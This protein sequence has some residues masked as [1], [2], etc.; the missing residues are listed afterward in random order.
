MLRRSVVVTLALAFIA[1]GAPNTGSSPALS[2][3]G[4]TAANEAP[5]AHRAPQPRPR[6]FRI[7]RFEAC[8]ANREQGE[9]GST[10]LRYVNWRAQE[11]VY[12]GGYSMEPSKW[13]HGGG[14]LYAQHPWLASPSDQTRVF[15]RLGAL[16]EWTP[17]NWPSITP[18][19]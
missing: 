10:D 5:L 2:L 19:R 6:P 12:G 15:R 18:C 1:I 13:R 8:V 9:P 16:G 17:D 7:G 4:G 11:G 14:L 3:T